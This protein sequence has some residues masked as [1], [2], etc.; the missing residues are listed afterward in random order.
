[1]TAPGAKKPTK[2]ERTSRTLRWLPSF[3]LQ[4]A[5]RRRRRT[6]KAH[7]IIVLA[8]HFEPAVVPGRGAAQAP[9]DEQ[10]RR[11]EIWCR[12]Y[13]ALVEGWRD[14]DGRPFVHTYFFPAEQYERSLLTQLAEHCRDGWGEVEIH[15]HHGLV[16]PDT[17]ENTRAQLIRFRDLLAGE[18]ECLSY[19]DG[20]GTPTYAFV[21]GNFALANSAGGR[22][23]GVD[24]ELEL[25]AET[26]CYADLSLP[27]GAFHPAH[28]SKI[29]SLY[30]CTPPLGRKA[31]HRS[32]KDLARGRTPITFPLMVQ[33]PLAVEF[34]SARRGSRIYIENGDLT[35]TNPPSIQRLAAWKRAR[36]SVKGRPDWIFIKLQCHG[37]DPRHREA[38]LGSSMQCFLRD[39]VTGAQERN[40]VLHFVSAREMVNIM[41]A[42]CDGRD[43][44]PGSYRDY[45]LK[46]AHD[47]QA[48]ALRGTKAEATV[49]S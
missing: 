22:F 33:G 26:G 43:G 9:P 46:R 29:N 20:R 13:P 19:W 45:R 44:N 28:I 6:G 41:L 7:L 30:E 4:S 34:S 40:E 24:N 23:C 42:A 1:M 14:A 18:H 3:V 32:G 35:T 37:M 12:E 49:K 5:M 36:I 10:Q 15:L 38:M 25:L 47:S 16:E 48:R 21:H 17:A 2:W 11:L 39:M 31:A 27:P 8:D